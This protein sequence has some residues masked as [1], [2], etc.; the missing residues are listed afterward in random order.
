MTVVV[1]SYYF[2]GRNFT[3]LVIN[4]DAVGKVGNNLLC[5]FM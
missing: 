5:F 1:L 3:F 4:K 2:I